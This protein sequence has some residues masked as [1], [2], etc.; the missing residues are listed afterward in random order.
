MSSSASPII[1]RPSGRIPDAQDHHGCRRSRQSHQVHHQVHPDL[2]TCH[3]VSGAGHR[4][5]SSSG[6]WFLSSWLLWNFCPA[7]P[8]SP[9]SFHGPQKLRPVGGTSLEQSLV[10]ALV[11]PRC[12]H[13]PSFLFMVKPRRTTLRRVMAAVPLIIFSV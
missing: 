8:S 9:H 6:H 12:I 4:R 7:E 11:Y 10:T 3:V 2:S 1:A 5:S 13:G